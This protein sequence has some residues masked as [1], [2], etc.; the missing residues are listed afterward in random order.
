MHSLGF[1]ESGLG[2]DG[3]GLGRGG[4]NMHVS[5]ILAPAFRPDGTL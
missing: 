1:A 4:N 2:W 5:L 3:V